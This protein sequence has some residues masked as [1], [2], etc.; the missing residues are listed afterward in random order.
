MSKKRQTL[1]NIVSGVGLDLE[2]TLLRAWEGGFEYLTSFD[3]P[4]KARD[5]KK[6]CILLDV[7]IGKEVS[8][9]AYWKKLLSLGDKELRELL[10]SLGFSWNLRT[11]R[12]PKGAISKLKKEKD[13]IFSTKSKKVDT[14]SAHKEPE[15]L[16][17]PKIEWREIG[18]LPA[19]GKIRFLT[20]D[21]VTSFH[22]ALAKDFALHR[23]PIVPVG[24]KSDN[25]LASA[26]F[27]PHT[28]IGRSLK[29]PTIEMASAALIHSIIHNHPFHNGNKRTALVSMLVMM[30]ENG[31]IFEE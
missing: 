23:D 25:L 30:D 19:Q 12:V 4:I 29:Y 21:E 22:L 11:S 27:R 20:P 17:P 24:V 10:S 26:V 13:K 7:P 15:Q 6:L 9:K 1:R 28:S 8:K 5:L 16:A 31:L 2:E 3:T 18:R 14:K